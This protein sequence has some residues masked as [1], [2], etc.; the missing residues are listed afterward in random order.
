MFILKIVALAVKKCPTNLKINAKMEVK[1]IIISELEMTNNKP[2]CE[3]NSQ[4]FQY[5]RG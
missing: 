4:K 3:P 5:S 2:A 1:N